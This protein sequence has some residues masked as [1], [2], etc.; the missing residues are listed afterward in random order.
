VLQ[1]RTASIQGRKSGKQIPIT[2]QGGMMPLPIHS[3]AG[4]RLTALMSKDENRMTER[5]REA[6][7]MSR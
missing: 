2:Q 6:L 5:G 4:G 3:S 7:G 1:A